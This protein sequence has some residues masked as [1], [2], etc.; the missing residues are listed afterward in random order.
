MT[1]VRTTSPPSDADKPRLLVLASTYPRWAGDPEP[2]FVH[3]L[4][5]RLASDFAVTVLG[6]SAPGAK[7]TETMDGVRVH[8]YRYAPAA[9]E[10]LVNDGGIVT[11]LGRNPWKWLLVPGFLFGLGWSLLRLHRTT[12]PDVIH[13]HW[14]L[15]QGLLAACLPGAA[16]VPLVVTSHGADLFALRA[17][18]L[19]ALKRFVVG[20]A[21]AVTVVSDAMREELRRIGANVS[22][23]EVRPM[24][25]DFRE[26]FSPDP[27]VQRSR[28][29]ILFVGRLVE[30]KGLRHLVDA[31]PA[32][33]SA[34]PSAFLTVAGFGPELGPLRAQA[35]RLGLAGK[36]R[37]AGAVSQDAL[38]ALYRRAAVC[39]APFIQAASGDREG[40]GLVVV[41]AAACGCPVV[42]SDVPAVR[43]VFEHGDGAALVP[44]G[45]VAALAEAVVETLAGMGPAIPT[46]KLHA[47]LEERFGWPGVA[48]GYAALLSGC[49]RAVP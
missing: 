43:Q 7:R 11:N 19:A 46:P 25:V 34:R 48:R 17:G 33:L 4:S 24:G 14:L 47:R 28:D 27:G 12:R 38:P 9:L 2:G 18:P 37:F 26:R 39:V 15:P 32:I 13:A 20:R 23:V 35:E 30:K 41:E 49:L 40:L 31:M 16:P 8:R 5:R 44:P 1:A 6:P 29:E 45:N 3:E 10:T 42:V 36:V 21:A 22:K